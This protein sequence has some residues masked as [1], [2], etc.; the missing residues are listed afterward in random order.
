M[1]NSLQEISKKVVYVIFT[2][3]QSKYVL[4]FITNG[5]IFVI[6]LTMISQNQQLI[7][8]LIFSLSLHNIFWFP[9]LYGLSLLIQA[10]I[11]MDMMRYSRCDWKH[12]IEDFMQT[13]L[14]GHLPGGWWK[15]LGR[16]T[17]YR[18]KHLSAAAIFWINVVE[19]VLLVTSGL[20]LVLFQIL[21]LN[22]KLTL[23][24]IFLI[25]TWWIISISV[26]SKLNLNYRQSVTRVFYW[27]I[28]YVIAWI[29]GAIILFLLVNSIS[30]SQF[31]LHD[32]IFIGT[33]SGITGQVLQFIPVSLLF[34]DLTM[35]TLLNKFMDIPQTI[36]V[37]FALRIIYSFSDIMWT[38][39]ISL[40]VNVINRN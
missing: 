37:I 21:P 19:F 26:K 15:W 39:V 13:Y 38:W 8:N 28:G 9:V 27:W 7:Y 17:V 34:R 29:L 5:L 14:M 1:N 32:A 18:A 31:S 40:V 23:F 3:H 4:K 11:W 36:V 24:P 20:S 6:F 10:A 16:I 25:L 2:R 33:T 12:A 30:T 22:L 35:V